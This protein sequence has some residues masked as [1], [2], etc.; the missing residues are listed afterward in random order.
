[1][2]T[3][4]SLVQLFS[5]VWTRPSFENA[6]YLMFAWIKTSGRAQISNFLRVRRHMSDLIP[7]NLEGEPKHVRSSTD[8]S[9]GRSG[10]S[11]RW[12]VDLPESSRSTSPT[13]T[14]C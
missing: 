11:S 7:R 1:M 10:A 13:M 4:L 8:C 3:I 9:P 2:G 5:S 12:G 14:S 6:R